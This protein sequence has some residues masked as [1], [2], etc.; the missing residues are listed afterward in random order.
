MPFYVVGILQTATHSAL[1]DARIAMN[2]MNLEINEGDWVTIIGGNVSSERLNL[3]K[4][5]KES[6]Y[7]GI[8]QAKPNN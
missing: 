3:I 6:F 2:H 1:D 4:I 8:E 5:T 7:K